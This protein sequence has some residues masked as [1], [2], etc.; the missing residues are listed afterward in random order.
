M[1]TAKATLTSVLHPLG[2]AVSKR[3]AC[4]HPPAVHARPRARHADFCVRVRIRGAGGAASAA[5]GAAAR[6]AAGRGAHAQMRRGARGAGRGGWSVQRWMGPRLPWLC[7]RVWTAPAGALAPTR[8]TTSR[9]AEL[10]GG[11]AHGCPALWLRSS[12]SMR[13]APCPQ[14]IAQRRA[15]LAEARRRRKERKA[16]AAAAAG[17]RAVASSRAIAAQEGSARAEVGGCCP[18]GV[19]AGG[20]CWGWGGEALLQQ[21]GLI[22]MI[23]NPCWLRCALASAGGRLGQ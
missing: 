4:T 12:H 20:G 19:C 9:K 2:A 10:V 16:A 14:A 8:T 15:Q 13:T 17:A 3:P 5:A 18:A 7:R 1:R 23:V 21:R 22:V 6:A 11:C